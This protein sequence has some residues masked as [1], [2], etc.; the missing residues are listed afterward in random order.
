MYAGIKLTL[1]RTWTR[2]TWSFCT[3]VKLGLSHWGKIQT[4]GVREGR[5]KREVEKII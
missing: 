4:E 1:N 3:G 5:G 2:F